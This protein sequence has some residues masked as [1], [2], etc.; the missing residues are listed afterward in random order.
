MVG[1]GDPT[2]GGSERDHAALEPNCDGM[3]PIIRAQLG[4]NVRD[5]AL[6]SCFPDTELIPDRF[7][8]IPG[9]NQLQNLNLP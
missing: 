7:V 8:G 3:H 4:E 5:V 6:D 9:G 2:F 1:T